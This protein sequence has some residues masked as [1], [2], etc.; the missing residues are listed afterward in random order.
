MDNESGF[1]GKNESCVNA[2]TDSQWQIRLDHSG[3]FIVAIHT[4]SDF[5][6]NT[7][8]SADV[9]TTPFPCCDQYGIA[10]FYVTCQGPV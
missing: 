8:M 6:L 5:H 2:P 7:V 9:H 10:V 3:L 4:T 1:H